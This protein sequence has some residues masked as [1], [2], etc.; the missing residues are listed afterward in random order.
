[1]YSS[2]QQQRTQ[3][4]SFSFFPRF[5]AEIRNYIWKLCVKDYPARIVDLREY[6]RPISR[7]LSTDS[8]E[9][10]AQ[11]SFDDFQSQEKADDKREVVGFK[12][13]VSAPAVLYVCRDSRGIA[14]QSYTKAFGTAEMPPETW[15][16]F[17]KDMLYLSWEFCS[18]A[19]DALGENGHTAHFFC[20]PRKPRGYF[21]EELSQ[22]VQKV[23]DLAVGGIWALGED[24]YR[25]RDEIVV[26]LAI[27]SNLER[28]TVVNAQHARDLTAGLVFTNEPLF[29]CAPHP[30]DTRLPL[31]FGK[32]LFDEYY[33]SGID[34]RFWDGSKP[35]P[36]CDTLSLVERQQNC[37][38]SDIRPRK[39]GG[40]FATDEDRERAIPDPELRAWR[41]GTWEQLYGHL[42]R[43]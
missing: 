26:L 20:R 40:L 13:R 16:D 14:Q 35:Y 3:N 31:G 27:F 37:F 6:R 7:A 42:P 33:C 4:S 24:L 12:S 32:C 9:S 25:K 22:E 38:T 18:A 21:V 30:E 2:M 5:P 1:M 36:W 43:K 39:I 17:E 34:S 11:S 8:E 28:F 15:I 23:K 41:S 10:L 19:L 29:P